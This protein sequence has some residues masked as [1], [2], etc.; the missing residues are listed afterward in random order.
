MCLSGVFFLSNT[1]IK[2]QLID[3]PFF[4]ESSEPAL[5]PA[6]PYVCTGPA[7]YALGGQRALPGQTY[8]L[9]RANRLC[10]S[11]S[12]HRSDWGHLDSTG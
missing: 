7:L 8:M 6:S 2:D 5:S 3:P 10:A 12:D 1:F 4:L 9:L 11:H